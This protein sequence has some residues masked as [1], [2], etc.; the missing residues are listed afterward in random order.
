MAIGGLAITIVK[1]KDLGILLSPVFTIAFPLL[2][3]L[4]DD[5]VEKVI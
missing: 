2:V 5:G 1:C 3:F 4:F